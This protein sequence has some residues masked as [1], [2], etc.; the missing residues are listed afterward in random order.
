MCV[1]GQKCETS[2]LNDEIKLAMSNGLSS[3]LRNDVDMRQPLKDTQ[4]SLNIENVAVN[5][6]KKSQYTF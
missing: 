3:A 6:T 4:N 2:I 1:S 5:A